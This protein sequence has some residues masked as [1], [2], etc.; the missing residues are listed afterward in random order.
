MI[1]L[2]LIR[3]GAT[4]WTAAG[5][6]QGHTDVPLSPHGQR[7]AAALAAARL[8]A[9]LHGLYASDLQRAWATAAVLATQYGLTAQPEPRLREVAFGRWEGSTY[10]ELQERDPQTLSAW[11]HDVLHVPPPGGETLLQLAERVRAVYTGIVA[12]HQGQTIALV[13]HGGALQACL[14]L[15]LGL[16]LQEHW[17]LALAPASLTELCLYPAGAILTR[18]NDTHHLQGVDHG[19]EGADGPRDELRGR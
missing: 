17:R 8:P 1:R 9:A 13:A 7:Q 16:P 4:A 3:H 19:S 10:A 2:V 18:F 11:E 6:F 5:R 15:A 12:A 14:C